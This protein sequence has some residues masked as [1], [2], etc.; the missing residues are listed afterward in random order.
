MGDYISVYTQQALD[1][2]TKNPAME[3]QQQELQIVA[4]MENN[5]DITKDRKS[6]V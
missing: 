5:Q 1:S 3:E 6:V 2:I 4:C